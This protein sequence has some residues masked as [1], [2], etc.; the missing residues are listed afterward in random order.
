L[1]TSAEY[2]SFFEEVLPELVIEA[3]F[4]QESLGQGSPP[5][6]PAQQGK[7]ISIE[8]NALTAKIYQQMRGTT[9]FMEY[10]DEDVKAAMKGNLW[11]A[12]AWYN[13]SPV[14]IVRIVGDGRVAFF[15]KDL[16]VI[17]EYQGWGI[18]RLLMEHIFEYLDTV[19]ADHAY[20]GLM[21]TVG[22]EEFYEKFGFMRRPNK[23]FGSGMLM[24]FD[25]RMKI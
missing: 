10:S 8:Q 7:V 6:I 23:K 1:N 13:G 17:P 2:L 12:V 18:G 20:V 9:N 14:G 24:F 15:I 21:S 5:N 11:S 25:R 4:S 22:K 16:V 19:A 3:S